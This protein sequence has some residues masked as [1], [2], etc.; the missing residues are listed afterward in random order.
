MPEGFK[1]ARAPLAF[2]PAK[3]PWL[4]AIAKGFQAR[5]GWAG[6]F[7]SGEMPMGVGN[8]NRVSSPYGL[9]WPFRLLCF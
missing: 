3:H 2:S 8:V 5:M 9:G 6:L 4:I 7:A 1:P